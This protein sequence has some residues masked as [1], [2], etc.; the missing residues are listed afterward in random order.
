ML[1]HMGMPPPA[2]VF[3]DVRRGFDRVAAGFD[4]ADFIHR[5]TFE[6]LL[7]R[8]SPVKIQPNNI[9][10]LGCATGTGS[11]QLVRRFRGS[12]IISLDASLAMLQR[13]R[14]RRSLLRRPSAL[15]GDASRM[16]LKDE[17]VDLIFA[18]MLLPWMDDLPACLLEVSRVLRRDGLFAFATFGPDSLSELREAWHSI[19]EDWHVNAYPD[20]HDLGDALVRAGLRD[21]VL[22]VDHLTVTYRDTAALYRDLSSAGARNCL[23]GRRQSLTGKS[24]FKA[25][26]NLLAARMADDILSLRLELVYGHAWGG[27]PCLPDGE[28]RVDPT[29]ISRRQRD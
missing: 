29:L 8:L 15:Q 12:R 3:R 10:D 27:G 28:F 6:E 2:L 4:D 5:V 7:Q 13:V 24:R 23:H 11:K 20:M 16:P 1:W 26:D 17:S 22:D 25:M 21:P 19:D 14:N 9:L 18:N